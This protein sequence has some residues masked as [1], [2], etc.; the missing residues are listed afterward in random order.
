MIAGM[1]IVM[2]ALGAAFTAFVI[3]LGVRIFNRRERC[4]K[5]IAVGLVAVVT[6]VGAYAAAYRH[7][8]RSSLPEEW[9]ERSFSSFFGSWKIELVPDYEGFNPDTG[10]FAGRD[11][12]FWEKVFAPAHWV[13]RQIR[14]DEWVIQHQDPVSDAFFAKHRNP[15]SPDDMNSL[16]VVPVE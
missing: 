3:W 1:A 9:R 6:V 4:A 8:V 14:R 15:I 16:E 10:Y 7:M 5:W 12:S 13:D 11:Q 2:P